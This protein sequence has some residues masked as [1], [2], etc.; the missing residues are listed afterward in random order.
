MIPTSISIANFKSFGSKSA[1]FPLRPITLIFGPN[2]SGKSSLLQS[3][4]YLDD[5]ME[6]GDPDVI[7]PRAGKGKVDLGG[8]R[9][10]LHRKGGVGHI[11]LG[12]TYKPEILPKTQRALWAIKES[13]AM[14]LTLGPLWAGGPLA[15]KTLS[16]ELDGGELLR[17]SRNDDGPFKIQILDFSHPAMLPMIETM[18]VAWSVGEPDYE[19]EEDTADVDAGYSDL[20]AYADDLDAV[21]MD[22]FIEYH[23]F[24]INKG[25]F[26]LESDDMLGRTITLK[27]LPDLASL[28]DDSE[29]YRLESFAN[30]WAEN[31]SEF[32]ENTLPKSFEALFRAFRGYTR[33]ALSSINHVP[34]LRDLPPRVFDLNQHP[35][36]LW[37]KIAGN[38]AL[39]QRIN[40]WLGAGFM[41]TRY[42]LNVREYVPADEVKDRVP[43]ALDDSMMRLF[44]RQGFGSELDSIMDALWQS[45]EKLDKLKYIQAHPELHDKLVE[46]E[47]ST[48]EDM[49]QSEGIFT[50][51][52]EFPLLSPRAKRA[53]AEQYIEDTLGDITSDTCDRIW[54]HYQENNPELR[55]FLAENWDSHKEAKEFN[56]RILPLGMEN[57]KEISLSELPAKIKVSLQDVGVG[58]SQVLPVLIAAFGEAE[59]IVAIEQP[60]IHIHPALQAELGDVFIESALGENKNTFLLETHSEHLILRLL[61]RVRETTIGDLSEWPEALKAACPDGIRPEDI[62]VLYVQPGAEGAEIIELP[63]TPDGDFSR[64]WPSGFFTERANELY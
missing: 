18:S 32:H 48:R 35:D 43:T 51:E 36:P 30:T 64:P 16:L 59:S 14:S 24:L 58:I 63:V 55:T 23:N 13:I 54:E 6:N 2:S 56:S 49:A 29:F 62:A 22:K 15:A 7:F 46:A 45:F 5:V 33:S 28:P 61:K 44:Q 20:E 11:V 17:A 25:A 8:F 34:P 21:N 4:M 38:P 50:E 31:L 27:A 60:E 9:Q 39:R 47:I 1:C 53:V 26:E 52:R 42:E 41:K 57:R 19:A 40:G 10:T 12:L 3:L 37:R